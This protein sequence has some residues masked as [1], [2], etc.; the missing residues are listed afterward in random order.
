MIELKIFDW[1]IIIS[2]FAFILIIGWYLRKWSYGN[3]DF[4]L[5]GRRNSAL[6]SAF[7]FLS[8]NLGSLEILGW[9]GASYKYGMLTAHFY[10]IGAVPA[11]LFLGIFMMKFYYKKRI[12][13]V[14]GY[15]GERFD[16][17]TRVLSGV[18]FCI[19]TLLMSGVNIYLM[20][21]IFKMI[22][23]WNWHISIWVSGL[24][25]GIYVALGGLMS[26]IFTEVVQ[27]FL[28]WLGLVPI[29]F[30]AIAE[31]K[32]L[33]FL[34]N[35]PAEMAS[36][37]VNT[38][39]PSKNPMGVD[40]LGIILGLGFVLSF[41]YWTADFLVIQRAFAAESLRA[42]KLAPIIA[43]FFK[44][45]L[46]FVVT[47]GG[48]IVFILINEGKISLLVDE[49]GNTIT[50]SAL[51]ALIMRY[52]P[53]GLVGLGVTALLAGFMAGQAGNITAFNT[54]FTQDIYKPVFRENASENELV[55]VGRISTIVGIL[56]SIGAAYWAMEFPTIMDYIQAIFSWVN[57]PLFAVI[58]LGMF[59]KRITSAG[60]FWGLLIGMIFSFVVFIGVR[61][62]IVPPEYITFYSNP[63]EMA[64]NLWRAFWSF[65]ISF[66][67]TIFVSIFT[68]P[69][70]PERIK[71]LVKGVEDIDDKIKGDDEKINFYSKPEFWALVSLF[72]L[73]LLNI[74]FF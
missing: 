62:G 67:I 20:A 18:S 25:V 22:L 7:A 74:I 59:S 68:K 8:A 16:R 12:F 60:A 71:G 46:P 49:N 58:L 19:M 73:V 42:A 35:V 47:F 14:P 66:I 11:M 63:S 41:G 1:I 28:I 64:L 43:S 53:P 2:Y 36:L 65:L 17:K 32:G 56:I 9:T 23:G 15:V 40:F 44:M 21:L 29:T 57:A 54:A 51:P 3:E 24:T 38:L 13:S 45:F 34:Q 50:D 27:F 48:I 55:A 33:S 6:V 37:W 72:V 31:F 61:Q 30:F 39:D 26:A 69:E 10:W 70:N 4:F 5:A 52:F